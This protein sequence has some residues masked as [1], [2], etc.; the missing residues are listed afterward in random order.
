MAGTPTPSQRRRLASAGSAPDD[1]A[2][3]ARGQL[4]DLLMVGRVPVLMA[5]AHVDRRI[6]H[7]N[8]HW[9]DYCGMRQ[10]LAPFAD[11]GG[12]GHAG[13]SSWDPL[14]A[15]P[16]ADRARWMADWAVAAAGG[17]RRLHG[18]YRMIRA[19]DQQARRHLIQTWRLEDEPD[20]FS[21]VVCATDAEDQLEELDHLRALARRLETFAATTCHDLGEPLRAVTGFLELL[22]HRHGAALIAQARE[23]IDCAV[24]GAERMRVLIH[25]SLQRAR[26]GRPHERMRRVD[27]SSV[28]EQVLA[29]LRPAILAQGAAVAVGRLPAITAYPS[30]MHSIYLN[31]IGNALR[32][33]ADRPPRIE[34]AARRIDHAWEFSV[35]DNG[36]GIAS[37]DLERI[38]G[39]FEQVSPGGGGSGIGLATCRRIIEAHGNRI[40][41]RSRVGEGTTFIWSWQDAD[42]R[43]AAARS[44]QDPSSDGDPAGG[45]QPSP[46][47]EAEPPAGSGA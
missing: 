34:I 3:A 14:R 21:W 7:V 10:R 25:S 5:L 18:H 24:S 31:L 29:D 27:L 13:A 26:F 32:Y 35:V 41:A 36:V 30:E 15:M 20:G 1:D 33:R 19:R 16:A 28:L 44:L 39:M 12:N 17:A 9:R 2:A 43:V 11:A 22:K 38:F 6:G 42:P 8:A 37:A 23:F 40:W 45:G 4:R 47:D 46:W